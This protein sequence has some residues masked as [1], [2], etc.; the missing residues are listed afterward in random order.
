M[1]SYNAN[2]ADLMSVQQQAD[3]T[4]GA[5]LA[6]LINQV[7]AAGDGRAYGGASAN[8]GREYTIGSRPVYLE[9]ENADVDAVGQGP[10]TES[11]SSDVEVHFDERNL[12]DYDLFNIKYLILP[13]DHPPPVPAYLLARSGRHTLWE[14]ATSGY[15]EVVDTLHRRSSLTATTSVLRQRVSWSRTPCS[16]CGFQLLLSTVRQPRPPPSTTPARRQAL[17]VL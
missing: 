7:K 14:V 15:L 10:N 16:N 12:A 17:R 6:V 8:W 4:D 2:G 13:Q 9:L 11:L 3:A 5:D 1:A